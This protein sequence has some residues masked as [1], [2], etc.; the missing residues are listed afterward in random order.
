MTSKHTLEESS[1]PSF[2]D[3][4]A[5]Y[6]YTLA[7]AHNILPIDSNYQNIPYVVFNSG[8]IDKL[9]KNIFNE[10]KLFQSKEM[11]ILNLILSQED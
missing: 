6:V 11:N 4:L 10:N 5:R 2:R 3:I 8:A 1:N 9:G 7:L